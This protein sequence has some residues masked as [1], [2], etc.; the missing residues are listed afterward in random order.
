MEKF[1]VY[2]VLAFIV[3]SVVFGCV[4]ECAQVGANVRFIV[5]GVK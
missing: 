1:L 2:C 3:G 5:N 4:K